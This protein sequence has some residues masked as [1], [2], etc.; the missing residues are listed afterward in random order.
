[1]MASLSFNLWTEPWIRVIRR[2]GR[3]DEIGIGTCLTDAHELAALSDPSPLVACGTHRL[4]TAIL[5]A[6]HQPQNIGEIAALLHNAKFDI[7]R[8]QAFEKNHA[9]RFD[10]FDP[11]A[12]FLQTGDVPL[13]SNHNPQP[14]ARLF[15]E[16]PV[17]TERVHFTHVTDD[18]HRIC[19][20]CCARGLVTAPA[21]ASSGG[22]GILHLQETFS[23]VVKTDK[24]GLSKTAHT[25]WMISAFAHFLPG[26]TIF[27][28]A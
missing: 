27:R 16:I 15:A 1:M 14:V 8:L 25:R 10:L 17:A 21:F 19:P 3:D 13:H 26:S 20:A 11:H 18:R 12:P 24:T 2:D 5:Q 22:A 4:L 7:N 9:G 6:I 23:D 28:L